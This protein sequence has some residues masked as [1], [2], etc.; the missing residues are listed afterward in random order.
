MTT[1]QALRKEVRKYINKA[2][3][4]SLRMVKAI[5]EIEQEEEDWD[6]L[7]VELQNMITEGIKEADEGKG[8]PYEEVKKKYPQYFGKQND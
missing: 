8:I 3:H 6:D 7:P 2:D 5:L 1:T 4:K